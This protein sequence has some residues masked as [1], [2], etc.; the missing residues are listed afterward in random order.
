MLPLGLL[1]IGEKAEVLKVISKE[2]QGHR[3]HGKEKCEPARDSR[4]EDM[5]LRAGKTVEMLN[6]EGR[7]PLLIKV[8]GSRLAIGRGMAMKIIVRRAA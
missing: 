2:H 6:N 8:D 1:S 3:C 5:G 7:G 4:V